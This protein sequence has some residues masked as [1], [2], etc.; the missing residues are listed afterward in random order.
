MTNKNFA[1]E[2]MEVAQ[3]ILQYSYIPI[4]WNDVKFTNEADKCL[5]NN[6]TLIGPLVTSG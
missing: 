6:R 3:T 2:E 5:E 1:K 4:Y